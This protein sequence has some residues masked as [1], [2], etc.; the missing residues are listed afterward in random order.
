MTSYPGVIAQ[1]VDHRAQL[2]QF[3]ADRARK[4]Q[5]SARIELLQLS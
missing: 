3:L 5:A 4:S 2:A 1:G